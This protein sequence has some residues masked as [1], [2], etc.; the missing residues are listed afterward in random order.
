MTQPRVCIGL[1]VYS[2]QNF[3]AQ[4]IASLR[5][6]RFRDVRLIISDNAP[7]DD[8]PAIARARLSPMQR[9][10]CARGSATRAA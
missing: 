6:Q 7:T 1:P 5:D 10:R 3:L 4:A 8:R 2:G 9:L